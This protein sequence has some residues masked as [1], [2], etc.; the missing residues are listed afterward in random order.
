M[1]NLK[2]IAKH[3]PRIAQ[4]QNII[5]TLFLTLSISL[6][7]PAT[8]GAASLGVESGHLSPCPP[9]PNCVVIQN[10]DIQHAIAPITYHVERDKA[11][12]I[13]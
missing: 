11:K 8:S 9:S 7:V 1:F 10:G 2:A 12:E 3:S 5:F 13:V 4:L 6:I